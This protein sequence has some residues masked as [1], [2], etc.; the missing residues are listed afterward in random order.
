[1]SN[2]ISGK[3]YKAKKGKPYCTNVL[4]YISALLYTLCALGGVLVIYG[5]AVRD[6]TKLGIG[7]AV[8]LVLAIVC[9]IISGKYEW[10]PDREMKEF[11]KDMWIYSYISPINFMGNSRCQWRI[12]TISSLEEKGDKL[13]IKGDISKREE[14]GKSKKV[15]EL[16]IRTDFE[17]YS[18]M[19]SDL[20][21]FME[22]T[23]GTA[24]TN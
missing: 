5:Y 9:R 8:M 10:E 6:W 3:L 24:T 15:K 22:K 2:G 7:L 21:K 11:G 12:S 19:K 1:M 14:I 4:A 17:D 18:E 13:K 16:V 20:E 23:K